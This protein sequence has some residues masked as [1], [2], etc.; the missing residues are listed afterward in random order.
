MS[1]IVGRSHRRLQLAVAALAV[2]ALGMVGTGCQ[3]ISGDYIEVQ[4]KRIGEWTPTSSGALVVLYRNS[5][6]R[7]IGVSSIA[8]NMYRDYRARGHSTGSA[9]ILTLRFLRG[10]CGS[11]YVGDR[12]RD[13]TGDD[14]YVDFH[15]ALTDIAPT[16][17]GCL[18]VTFRSGENWTWRNAS[19]ENC[20]RD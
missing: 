18:A 5:D 8:L 16:L 3:A 11:G 10:Y 2:V 9:S 7:S 12:C 14:E 15:D 19:D 13:A 17:G 6:S 4:G 20:R 1:H